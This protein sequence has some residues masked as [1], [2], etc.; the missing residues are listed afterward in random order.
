VTIPGKT[1]HLDVQLNPAGKWG[2]KMTGDINGP[3]GVMVVMSKDFK[4]AELNIKH[5]ENVYAH[6]T[7]NGNV[8]MNGIIPKKFKYATSYKFFEGP[9]FTMQKEEGQAK[10]RFDGFSDKKV[11]TVEFTPTGGVDGKVDLSL[12]STNP[13][14]K[15]MFEITQGGKSYFKQEGTRTVT[16]DD[17]DKWQAIET[18]HTFM[19]QDS[20]IYKW[21]CKYMT[22][23][24]PCATSSE[25]TQKYFFDKKNKN[26][27]LNKFSYES[28]IIFGG[29]KFSSMKIDTTKT[30]F[31]VVYDVP[32][33]PSYYP[34]EGKVDLTFT[35]KENFGSNFHLTYVKNGKQVVSFKQDRTI[36][37]DATKFEIA[38]ER[39]VEISEEFYN[40]NQWYGKMCFPV[41]HWMKAT[42]SRKFFFDK[43]NKNFLFNK[44]LYQ[45][46]VIL[47]GAV[48]AEYKIN[49][50]NAPYVFSIDHPIGVP[51]WYPTDGK[52]DLTFEPKANFGFH[53]IYTIVHDGV[54]HVSG[55]HDV[56]VVNNADKFE[57][58]ELSKQT[59]DEDSSFY[60]GHCRM[61]YPIPCHKQVEVARKLFVDKKNTNFLFNKMT[62]DN[63]VKLD[64][65]V[66]KTV[67]LDT[68]NTPYVLTWDEPKAPIWTPSP[69]NMFG[70]K[71]WMV[72]VDHKAGTSLVVSSNLADMKL[73]I[74][75]KPNMFVE[76]IR[77]GET[78]LKASSEI[79]PNFINTQLNTKMYFP[80]GSVFC[81]RSAHIGCY[82]KYE[83]DLKVFVDLKNKNVYLN[84]FSINAFVKKNDETHIE[85]EESTKVSPYVLKINAPHMLPQLFD[86]P[87][88]NTLEVTINH[89]EGKSLH[90]QTNAPEMSSFKVTT[91]GVQRKLE[92]NGEELVVVDY[93]KADK[94]FKQVL[95]LPNREHVTI[96][97]DWTTWDIQTNK[98]HMKI[99][100][101]TRK[102]NVDIDYFIGQAGKMKVTFH[103]ENPMLGKYTLQRNVN[104]NVDANQID[105]KWTGQASFAKGPLAIFSPIATDAKVNYSIA[106]M[107]LN[108]NIAKT[109]AGQKWGLDVSQ[110]KISLISGRP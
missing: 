32:Q 66:V 108:A 94:K 3:L 88:R 4:Q 6:I 14:F 7:C 101:P 67:K 74:M 38:E 9:A 72:T 102:F 47:D 13:G 1:F 46:K 65:K 82:D 80:T 17:A 43:V 89:Q 107:V 41:A 21:H 56:T 31:V 58:N 51:A 75:R 33:A 25:Q 49:T 55:D 45:D 52:F 64:G 81:I 15:Y 22:Y 16:A 76:F 42:Q 70:L 109:I 59:M 79:T 12:E 5:R 63:Q 36:T 8:E 20:P 44:M 24:V 93:T 103:G 85:F 84:K 61:S 99:E 50:V 91:D 98:V 28:D 106:N 57:V 105:A 110:N 69:I 11:F 19:A 104:W 95:Q 92:L 87:R 68:V 48:F 29:K 83:A 77:N 23:P 40:M 71:K 90:I 30:P 37:N 97:L 73:T 60:A 86:D 18:S 10:V 96:S 78:Y 2:V 35:P 34:L 26:F 39:D 27:L 54:T 100:A 62:Y 53:M